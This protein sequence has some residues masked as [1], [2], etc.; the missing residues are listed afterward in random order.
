A[1]QPASIA[2]RLTP[3][4]SVRILGGPADETF[5]MQSFLAD[6]PLSIDGGGGVNTLDY[7]AYNRLPGLVAWY[8]GEGNANNAIAGNNGAL[9][10]GIAFVPGKVGQA[11][12][13]NGLDSYVQVAASSAI[14]TQTISVEAWVNSNSVGRDSYIL[15]KGAQG[16]VASS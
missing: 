3:V 15:A 1:P 5:V 8:P 16:D 9:S 14:E 10:G 2:W 12:S 7:S 13:F 4:S 11:F 6:T